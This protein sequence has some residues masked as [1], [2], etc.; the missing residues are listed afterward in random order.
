MRSVLIVL[1]TLLVSKLNAAPLEPWQQMGPR[2]VLIIDDVGTNLALGEAAL[3]LPGPVTY[4]VLPL[5]PHARHLSEEASRMDKEVIL[6]APMANLHHLRLG[7]GAL[8]PE[9]NKQELQATL[10]ED[11]DAV[12]EAIGVNNHMG[13]LMTQKSEQMDWVMEV[14]RARKLFFVDSRTTAQTKAYDSA[15]NAGIPAL[16]RDVFLDNE[17]TAEAIGE[18]FLHA[19]K[20]ARTKGSVVVIGHPYPETLTFLEQALPELGEYGISLMSASAYLNEQA[21]AVRRQQAWTRAQ[22]PLKS[23]R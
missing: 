14:L 10:R 1:L 4:A 5:T 7:P 15:M 11:L 9:Q 13:S 6:H 23:V 2:M 19:V 8:T 17:R 12:P 20:L 18:R 21:D 3:A 22:A 16:K